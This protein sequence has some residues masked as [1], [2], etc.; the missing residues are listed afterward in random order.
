MY[1][2]GTVATLPENKRSGAFS[3]RCIKR[4]FSV[5]WRGTKK[6]LE[7]I[8]FPVPMVNGKS[9]LHRFDPAPRFLN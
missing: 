2:Y 1:R 4:I 9:M 7:N 6:I 5:D 3:K 8:T